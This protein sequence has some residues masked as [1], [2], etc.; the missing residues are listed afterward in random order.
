MNSSTNVI[1]KHLLLDQ[2]KAFTHL[3]EAKQNTP[4]LTQLL[5]D[6]TRI[7]KCI[8]T[9]KRIRLHYG[10]HFFN[11]QHL[12]IFQSL[13]E[14]MQCFEKFDA[15]LNGAEIN[16]GEKRAVHHH[17][18]R[19]P[20]DNPYTKQKE[21][22]YA[23]AREIIKDGLITD[24]VQIGIGGSFLGP[25][26]IYKALRANTRTYPPY[27][28]AHFVTNM[29]PEELLSTLRQ[30]K[31]KTTLFII[32][33]KSGT[34]Q[35][36]LAN[37]DL[38]RFV[39]SK[40]GFPSE[41]I[42]EQCITITSPDSPM[43]NDIEFFKRFYITPEIGGRFSTTSAIGQCI[44]SLCFGPLTVEAL[45]EGAHIG[46][47]NAK[48]KNILENLSL[49][50]AC[51]TLLECNGYN[52]TTKG[53]IPYSSALRDLPNLLQQL[54]CESNG[55][56][57]SSTGKPLNY[58][59]GPFIFGDIGTNGQHAFFQ[60][61]H[62]GTTI[63]PIQF[64]GVLKHSDNPIDACEVNIQKLQANLVSQLLAFAKGDASDN[65]NTHFSGNRP[66]SLVMIDSLN[67]RTMGQLLAF[68][69]NSVMFSGFL[70]GLNSYDQE[71]VQLGKTLTQKSLAGNT[72]KTHTQLNNSVLKPFD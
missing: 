54:L 70:W 41:T 40:G 32:A 52:Y 50:D 1:K 7:E 66:S 2:C 4:S 42:R 5:E 56:S 27:M 53:I 68:Y 12:P 31:L 10:T 26:W 14:E 37:F 22:I 15:L 29:D 18:L 11:D 71:G 47:E 28:K 36:T 24:V 35:E 38:L 60:Q 72:S 55:K 59:T 25:Q 6:E 39:L 19:S 64:V 44:L 3:T 58:L 61:L 48:S 33:S 49:L 63:T 43:D 51:L 16:T 20:E 65:L 34:T 23:F 21:E 9:H 45:L 62:Q 57:V 69:E 17:R 46:D 8:A 67:P 30:V 13:I